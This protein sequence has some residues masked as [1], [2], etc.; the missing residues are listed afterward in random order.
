MRD[1]NLK[2]EWLAELL[3]YCLYATAGFPR[4]YCCAPRCSLFYR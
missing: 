4:W 3:L 1:Y 2:F